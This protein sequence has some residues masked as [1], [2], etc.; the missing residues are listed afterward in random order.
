MAVRLALEFNAT[1]LESQ[2]RE[3]TQIEKYMRVCLMMNPGFETVVTIAPS[4]PLLAEAACLLM[5][6]HKTFHLPRALLS[7]FERP[8][9]DKGD[10]GELICLVLLLMARDVAAQQTSSGAIEV[11]LFMRTLLASKWSPIIFD[12]KPA[13]CSTNAEEQRPFSEVFAGSKMHFNHF[14]K[15]HDFKVI[16]RAFLWRL[17]ARGA[18]VLCANYQWGVDILLPFLYFDNKVGRD[19]VSAIFIQVK[20]DKR[21]SSRPCLFLFDAMNPYFL[22]FF[23]VD[24]QKPVPI[25]RMVFALA[26]NKACV[27][28]VENAPLRRNPPRNAR[29]KGKKQA[30]VC[31][32]YTA[33]DI[34]CAGTSAE[35]F[36]VVEPGDEDVYSELLKVSRLFPGAY[37][38]Y[39]KTESAKSARRNMNPGTAAH[40]DHWSRFSGGAG[41]LPREDG[42]D[43]DFDCQDEV[44]D[45]DVEMQ[46]ES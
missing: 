13:R 38:A 22:G 32:A 2:N 28:A 36:S 44:V 26:A 7:E 37:E 31:A 8:G 9:L 25:I 17:I 35:T 11:L 29:S 1:V 34:W 15:V 45:D 21:F 12:S 23:D 19:N 3:R 16:N 27:E 6:D 24:E 18:A 14:I 39:T 40:A 30:S 5:Q 33:Y 42:L 10:R 46:D 4:E 43:V 41:E 20:N